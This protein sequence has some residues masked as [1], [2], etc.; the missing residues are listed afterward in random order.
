RSCMLL[1][2]NRDAE[3][4]SLAST[5]LGFE[6]V[7]GSTFASPHRAVRQLLRKSK[8]MHLT[9]TPDGPRGP[10]R[11]LAAGAIYLSSKLQMPLVA[12]GMG[13]DRPWRVNSWDRFA[14]PRPY[15]RA[16]CIMS[17]PI[18]IPPALS[19]SEMERH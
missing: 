2:D 19:S 5:H 12:L 8:D 9:L 11:R 17:P 1:S 3:W 4:L 10:R 18:Q 7:R 15:S 14:I 13:Y 6:A 16:R